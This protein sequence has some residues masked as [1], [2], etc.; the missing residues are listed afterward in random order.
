MRYRHFAILS[1]S[2]RFPVQSLAVASGFE[3]IRARGSK[4][5]KGPTAIVVGSYLNKVQAERSLKGARIRVFLSA[6][7]ARDW[8]TAWSPEDQN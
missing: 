5:H 3:R 1:D 2:S 7:E 6:D 4:L 8:L